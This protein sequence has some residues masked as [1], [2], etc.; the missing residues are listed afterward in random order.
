MEY[1]QQT[2][3]G[4][5]EGGFE[6]SQETANEIGHFDVQSFQ[7]KAVIW[8]LQNNHPLREF[9]TPAFKEMIAAVNPEAA[10]AIWKN[11]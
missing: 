4:L 1:S 5:I 10:A 11:H 7:I 3:R 9:E 2:L 6:V 8:L